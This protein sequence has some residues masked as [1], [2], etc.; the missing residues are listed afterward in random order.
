MNLGES[1]EQMLGLV[2]QYMDVTVAD[3]S[4]VVWRDTS[5]RTFAATIDGLGKLATMLGVPEQELW[6][7]IPGVTQQDVQRWKAEAKGQ[8]TFAQFAA[9]LERQNKPVPAVA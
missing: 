8:D 7:R 4:E 3:D 2:G 6:E 1:H 9:L 5:A